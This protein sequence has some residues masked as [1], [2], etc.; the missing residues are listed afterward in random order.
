MKDSISYNRIV[1]LILNDSSSSKELDKL[2]TIYRHFDRPL[3]KNVRREIIKSI[4]HDSDYVCRFRHLPFI[5]FPL[6]FKKYSRKRKVYNK[7][8]IISLPSHHDAF[9]YKLYSKILYA[10]YE[11]YL[12]QKSIGDLPIAYR[13][14]HSNITGAKEAIDKITSQSS[15]IIKGDFSQFFDNLNHDLLIKNVKK[16]LMVSGSSFTEDWQTLLRSLM[17]HRYIKLEDIEKIADK[18]QNKPYFSS[19]KKLDTLLKNKDLLVSK[20]QRLG[21]PQGTAL[22]AV[23]ANVYMI[24]F[25]KWIADYLFQYNGFYRRYSDDFIIV[26][27]AK[28]VD[29]NEGRRIKEEVYSK[30]SRKLSLTIKD[31]KTGVYYFNHEK[32]EISLF[33]SN[34]DKL[35][36]SELNYLG[37]SF[38]GLEVN[39]RPKTIYKFHYRGKKATTILAENMYMYQKMKILGDSIKADDLTNRKKF[40]KKAVD[41]GHSIPKRKQY[42]KMY[43]VATPIKMQNFMSYATNAQQIFSEPKGNYVVNILQQARKQIG[44]F[45]RKFHASRQ[46]FDDR[47]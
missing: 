41:S 33:D 27:P 3:S 14:G 21:I 4:L 19:L 22:S 6:T 37:F 16:V 9:L 24:E 29:F 17:D 40:I 11:N 15:W 32:R 31:S 13:K 2:T 43:L 8:R 1:K 25:D 45:Q 18:N 42:T 38:N 23:L 7:E 35:R 5:E 44:Y 10:C 46:K 36:K 30:S 47:M 20:R 12:V 28:S 39:L 26:I 34:V